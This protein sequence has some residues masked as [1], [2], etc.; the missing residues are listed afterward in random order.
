[1][2]RLTR[3]NE[4]TE[5]AE[6]VEYDTE[7]WKEFKATLHDLDEHFVS[8]AMN[9]LAIYEDT[10][11]EPHQ[12][13]AICCQLGE[14]VDTLVE[15][16]DAEEQGMLLRLPCKVGDKFYRVIRFCSM[17]G[18]EDKDTFSPTRSDCEKWCDF[19]H[20]NPC[21]KEYRITEDTFPS[22]L[23]IIHHTEDIGVS[24]FLTKA[25]AEKALKEM[26]AE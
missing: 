25:E 15:Y 24:Y 11:L 12:I 7:E 17:C 4:Q 13:D 6:L 16:E 8:T 3:W 1:M 23:S 18:R 19:N 14:L 26:D 10:G 20:I 9:Q 22:L 21:D 5:Q 2:E